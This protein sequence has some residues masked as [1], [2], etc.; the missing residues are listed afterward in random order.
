M[1]PDLLSGTFRVRVIDRNVD[2]RGFGPTFHYEGP[3]TFT[4]SPLPKVARFGDRWLIEATCLPGVEYVVA[5]KGATS[6]RNGDVAVDEG[7]GRY[8]ILL[9]DRSDPLRPYGASGPHVT[10]A[11]EMAAE[12]FAVSEGLGSITFR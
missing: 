3:T 4:G 9:L 7:D 1:T 10:D 2:E 8:C 6:Y 12:T 5:E 11:L